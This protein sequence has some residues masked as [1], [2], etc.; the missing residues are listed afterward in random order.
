LLGR[1][2]NTEIK[3]IDIEP[4]KLRCRTHQE[5]VGELSSNATKIE[6]GQ[7]GQLKQW[8][9]SETSKKGGEM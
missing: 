6:C 1:E 2:R 8:K 4:N 7:D 3:K 9:I 5:S